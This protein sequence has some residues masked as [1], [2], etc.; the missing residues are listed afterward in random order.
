MTHRTFVAFASADRIL[1]S[2]IESACTPCPQ[3]DTEYDLWNRND[4]SGQPIDRSVLSWVEG[5]D[6]F[7]ADISEPNPNVTYEIGLAIG[8]AKPTRLLRATNKPR[9]IIEEIGL[10]HNTGYDEYS[11]KDDLKALLQKRPT[12]APWP[13]PRRNR[14]QPVYFLQPS[15]NDAILSRIASGIKKIIKLRF[16]TFSPREIDRL[17][18]MEAFKQVSQSF[19]VLSVWHSSGVPDHFRQNQR[20]AFVI[21]L[22]RGLD[23]PFLMF[24]QANERLPLDLDEIATRW[25]SV[26]DIDMVLRDFRDQTYESQQ[27]YTELRPPSDRFL[28]L[29]YCGDPA[30]ENEATQLSSYFLETE[31][32]R[33]TL[34]G[35]VNV[36]LGRKGSG[37][38]AIFIQA[39]DKTR[40][41]KNNIVIDL[42]PEGFQLI[43]LKEF[44][45]EQLSHGLRKEFIAA[46]WEYIIWLEICYKLLEKDAKRVR[47]DSRLF[48]VY[49]RLERAYRQRVQ[50]SGD[51]SERLSTLTDRILA[52]Y[53][54]TR[55]DGTSTLSSAHVLQIVYGAE[56]HE[57]REEVLQYLRLKGIVFFLFD[58]LDRFWTSAGF[59]EIDSHLIVGL[60]ESLSDIRRKFAKRD[61]EFRWAIFL[62]SD[63]YEFIVKGMAD[64][65]KLAVASLE[66][67]DEEL[68]IRMFKNRILSGFQEN[69]AAWQEVWEAI[70]VQA[71]GDEPTL[72]F[73]VGGS[74]MRP[75]YLIRLF[76]TAR[77]RAVALG[78]TKIEE[79]DYRYALEELGWQVLEDFDRELMDIVPDAE[80]LM[81]DIVQLGD[82]ISLQSLRSVI[83]TRVGKSADVEG[84]ID[85]L[86]WTGRIGI[87]KAQG[88][89]M[90]ISDCG[91]KRPYVR[92]LLNDPMAKVVM[93]HPTIASLLSG[94]R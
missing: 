5:A 68:L 17:T 57:M 94:P 18:A 32:F 22:A 36:L 81:F 8:M 16:R 61:I 45:L 75:R 28:D 72:E 89:T 39:R 44:I 86:I 83:A 31:Q 38:T 91:F 50:G 20:A 93:F 41:N 19:G 34:A 63:V 13:S 23:I 43:R 30:A 40:S 79:G 51:F 29:A 27:A 58:N 82:G 80:Q 12:V 66:W 53:N 85:V 55:N 54:E 56:L 35:Q 37:K 11:S 21:G 10:F 2:I 15:G 62:R 6:A 65:G 84:V 92:S 49:D 67:N 52:R 46:F 88:E 77:R 76:E 69:R 33:L 7:V 78:R 47:Y 74:L 48:E 1:A 25:S 26:T 59:S 90:Y 70:S 71:I 3:F 87:Q 24:A 42:Q 60:I 14:E 64:Y 9:Q 73:L 4:V